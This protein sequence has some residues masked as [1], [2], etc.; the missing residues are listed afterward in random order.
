MEDSPLIT[1][2]LLNYQRP[3]NMRRLLASISLQKSP[4]RIFLWNNTSDSLV[5]FEKINWIIQSSA[6][7]GCWA[8]WLAAGFA[9]T[10][11]VCTIDDDLAFSRPDALCKI[12]AELEKLKESDV[13][14]GLEGVILD[15]NRPYYVQNQNAEYH[16]RSRDQSVHVDIVKGRFFAC[17][18]EALSTIS[19]SPREREDDI[20]ICGQLSKG[21]RCH[22]LLPSGLYQF[23][24]EL[25]QTDQGN[26][27]DSN[28]LASRERAR[29]QYFSW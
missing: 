11:Y 25:P 21:R 19:I 22:H 8:R 1:I 7:V 23:F 24:E 12:L 26:F 4:S 5:D 20:A 17:R 3:E 14:I 29:R 6:N 2:L 16:L 13:G 9:G 18:T 10:K 15:S 27:T 28:H